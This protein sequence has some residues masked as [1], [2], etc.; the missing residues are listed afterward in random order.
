[1]RR[2]PD[3]ILFIRNL[4]PIHAIKTGYHEVK[5]WSDWVQANPLFGKKLKGKTRVWLKYK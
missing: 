1:M 5:P 4:L 2:F 3:T